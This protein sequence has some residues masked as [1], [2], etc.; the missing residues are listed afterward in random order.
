[1]LFR[2]SFSL[3]S[4]TIL[5][6]SFIIVAYGRARVSFVMNVSISL[7]FLFL[8]LKKSK[9]FAVGSHRHR[10]LLLKMNPCQKL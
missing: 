3:D 1:M 7:Q 5:T 2:I 10:K 8:E 9:Y 4:S 6:I